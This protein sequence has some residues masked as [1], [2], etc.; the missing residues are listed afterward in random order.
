MDVVIKK[1]VNKVKIIILRG[2]RRRR[3]SRKDKVIISRSNF[4]E[5]RANRS[6]LSRI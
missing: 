5:L 6:R 3:R 4:T 2:D 1:M